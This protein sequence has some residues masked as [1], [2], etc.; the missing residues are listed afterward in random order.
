[1]TMTRPLL[2]SLLA[3]A[4]VATLPGSSSAARLSPSQR[5]ESAKLRATARFLDGGF[6]CAA[7]AARN[8]A[9]FE[10]AC[11]AKAED[12]FIAAFGRINARGGCAFTGDVVA[13]L[14]LSGQLVTELES[15]LRPVLDANRCAAGKLTALAQRGFAELICAARAGEG[16]EPQDECLARV[17]RA[18][19][20]RIAKAER[21]VPCLTTGDA[22]TL[23][24]SLVPFSLLL[25]TIFGP[26][27][28]P[29]DLTAVVDGSVIDLAWTPPDPASGNTHVKVV[30]RLN[31]PP[32][33]A[34]D[35]QAAQVFFGTATSTTDDLTALFPD[36]AIDPHTYHYGAFGCTSAGACGAAASRASVAPTLIQALHVGGYVIHWRHAAADVC[37][38][39]QGLGTAAT[40]SSPNW[41][42]SCDANCGTATAR[43]LNATGVSDATAIGQAFD[44]RGIPVGRVL[45]SEYCRNVHTAEL[46]DFGPTIEQTPG[47]T[48]FVY[49]EVNRCQNTRTL[50]AQAPAAGTNTAIIGHAGFSSACPPIDSLAWGEAIV[51]KPDGLGGS[52]PVARVSAGS[53]TALP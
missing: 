15:V 49:D 47:I 9:G 6:R 30:R 21:R 35:P 48:Y 45:S 7:R 37:T 20:H 28:A 52:T 25:Q 16:K 31:T 17:S 4:L 14:A 12:R 29:D 8:G 18:F 5:C 3:M 22:D 23:E 41:W 50:L 40:T 11:D 19:A 43:Q 33:A 38:D 1:M 46:M 36:T 34:D 27:S 39:Q 51:F 26:A 10:P 32:T 24:S 13:V 53:W 2:T 44:A 42:K